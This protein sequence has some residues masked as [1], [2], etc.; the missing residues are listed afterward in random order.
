MAEQFILFFA[1]LFT[2]YLCKKGGLIDD[3]MNRSINK[4]ILYLAYPCLI[5]YRIG[6]LEMSQEIFANFMIALFISLGLMAVYGLYAYGYVRFRKFPKVDQGVAEFSMIS[7][8]N[9]FMGFPIALAFFGEYGLL[10]MVAC[11]LSLNIMFFSYGIHLMT[12]ESR[13]KSVTVRGVAFRIIKLLLNPNILAAVIGLL[14]SI[15]NVQI[16]WVIQE[17]L[18]LMGGIA[19]PMVMVFIGSTLAGSS[20]ITILKNSL[21]LEIGIN[22]LLLLPAVTLAIVFFLP[23]DPLVKSICILSCAFPCAT[24]VSMLAEI[25]GKNKEMASEALFLTTIASLATLPFVLTLI[26]RII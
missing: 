19:T 13:I 22:K 10:Y 26:S 21:I 7:P 8:N 16:L 15:S 6:S 3:G 1:L 14:I 5:V 2:G 4:F 11:N 17:Y 20:L 18:R 24:T 9:G 12:R 25:H 23:I